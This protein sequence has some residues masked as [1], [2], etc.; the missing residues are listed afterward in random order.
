MSTPCTPADLTLPHLAPIP[1]K[2]AAKIL[3][4]SSLDLSLHPRQLRM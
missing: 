4:D 2:L 1:A 3:R